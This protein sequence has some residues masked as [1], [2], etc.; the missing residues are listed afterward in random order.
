MQGIFLLVVRSA[1]VEN[2]YETINF[3]R[4]GRLRP[5]EAG[6]K[7]I[8]IFLKGDLRLLTNHPFHIA[9][10]RSAA[11]LVVYLEIPCNDGEQSMQIHATHTIRLHHSSLWINLRAYKEIEGP[12]SAS[13]TE[14]VSPTGSSCQAIK[15]E[16]YPL[17]KNI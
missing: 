17:A 8:C 9:Q 7:D 11:S 3:H 4:E 1:L 5:F 15:R 10:G 14:A 13:S 12:Y 16:T 2:I 6:D